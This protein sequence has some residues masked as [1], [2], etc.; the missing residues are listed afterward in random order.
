M[1]QNFSIRFKSGEY[2]G[3]G[4]LNIASKLMEIHRLNIPLISI[5]KGR[6]RDAGNETIH[7]NNTQP[8]QLD[9]DSDIDKH[10]QII[11]LEWI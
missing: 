5:S 2:G 9:N 6:D 10:I 8:F 4:H 1:A 7:S 3:K 11:N